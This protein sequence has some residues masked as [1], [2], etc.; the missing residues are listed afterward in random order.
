[1]AER[2]SFQ[3]CEAC[4]APGIRRDQEGYFSTTCDKH[5]GRK[6]KTTGT[7]WLVKAT[8]IEGIGNGWL[9]LIVGL[10]DIVAWYV[11]K[12]GMP[13][14]TN[15]IYKKDNGQLHVE[16]SGGDEQTRGMADFIEHYAKKIDEHSGRI[17][18]KAMA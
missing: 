15:L 3:I 7:D 12:N 5:K 18:S 4:G 9:R 17:L 8:P 14:V 11:E 10:K 6:S 16:F 1:M 13:P 2:L